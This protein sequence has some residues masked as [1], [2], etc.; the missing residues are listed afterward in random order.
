MCRLVF[1]CGVEHAGRRRN[2]HRRI[3]HPARRFDDLGHSDH[4][5][6]TKC[7]TVLAR[8]AVGPQP[9]LRRRVP[10][11]AAPTA[12]PIPAPAAI[13]SPIPAPPP[14]S[15]PKISPTPA[16]TAMPSDTQDTV[17]VRGPAGEPL[18]MCGS[19]RA[20]TMSS[21]R[22][23]AASPTAPR[24]PDG[25]ETSGWRSSVTAP[26]GAMTIALPGS[27]GRSLRW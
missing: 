2:R 9:C 7:L 26:R 3:P 21:V 10:S 14:N 8:I 17:V 16:P 20:S 12:T 4:V 25:R 18:V 11:T 1:A 6:H 5:A 24:P 15:R 13:P 23:E 19:R 22:H 27:R